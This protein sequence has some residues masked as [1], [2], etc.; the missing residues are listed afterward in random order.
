[1]TSRAEHGLPEFPPGHPQDD[2]PVVTLRDYF[3]AAAISR[4][5]EVIADFVMVE[6]GFEPNTVKLSEIVVRSAK[7]A[8]AVAD[9]MLAE[10]AK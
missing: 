10:R 4:S 5:I 8:G 7:L 3:A 2:E 6:P 9:A 1:M